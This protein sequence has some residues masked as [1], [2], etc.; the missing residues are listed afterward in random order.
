MSSPIRGFGRYP[1]FSAIALT[2]AATSGDTFPEPR[3]AYETAAVDKPTRRAIPL[4]VTGEL[5]EIR[6]GG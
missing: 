1:N 4:N 3:K 5:M 6:P 2:R